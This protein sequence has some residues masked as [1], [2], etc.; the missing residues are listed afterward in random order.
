MNVKFK[1]ILEAK[2][3]TSKKRGKVMAPYP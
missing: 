2:V 3:G 1:N